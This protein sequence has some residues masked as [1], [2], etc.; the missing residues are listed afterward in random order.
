MKRR[1]WRSAWGGREG[2]G[3][4][5]REKEREREQA[6]TQERESL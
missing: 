1:E 6:C 3:E 4:I 2:E 5:E